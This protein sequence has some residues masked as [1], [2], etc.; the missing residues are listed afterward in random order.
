MQRAMKSPALDDRARRELCVEWERHR[1][2]LGTITADQR[3]RFLGEFHQHMD[4]VYEIMLTFR[5]RARH[6]GRPTAA[7]PRVAQRAATPPDACR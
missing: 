4:R 6:P 2:E 3:D 1:G 5:L 7:S